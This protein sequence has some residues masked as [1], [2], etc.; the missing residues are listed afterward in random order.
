[1]VC[2]LI[3][4]ALQAFAVGK[5]TTDP[6][7]P[8]AAPSEEAV[9]GTDARLG[10]K[11]TISETK[12]PVWK[13]LDKLTKS[14]GVV[15]RAGVGSGDWQVR[16]RKMN[17]YAKDLPLVQIMNSISHVMKFKWERQGDPDR[18]DATSPHASVPGKWTYRL[19]MDRRTLLDAEAQRARAEEKEAAVQTKRRQNA[20]DSF[21]KLSTMTA[22]EKEKLKTDNP[23]LY[24]VSKTGWGDSLGAFLREVPAVSE[25]LAGGQKINIEG[26]SLTS[27][28][29]TGLINAM[30]AEIDMETRFGGGG[31]RRTYPDNFDPA[32][33]TIWV[34]DSLDRAPASVKGMFLGEMDFR[35]EGGSVNSPLINPDND[36]VKFMGKMLLE[37]EQENRP[38]GEVMREHESE[39]T[40][41][42]TR[43]VNSQAGGEPITEH[44][45]DPSLAAKV[46]LAPETHE[47]FNVEMDLAKASGLAVVSDYFPYREMSNMSKQDPP[48]GEM[49]VKTALEKI[50]DC[51]IY[52]WDKRDGAIELRDRNWFR[53]RALQI[54]DAWLDKW[55]DELSTTGTIDIDSL[56]QI[57]QLTQEQL[58]ANVYPDENLGQSNVVGVIASGREI[59]RFYAELAAD[60]RSG[61]SSGGLDVAALTP[62]QSDQF[63]KL[64]STRN[65]TGLTQGKRAVMTSERAQVEKVFLYTFT[66]RVDGKVME[67]WSLSTVQSTKPHVPVKKTPPTAKPAK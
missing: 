63:S 59:L 55:R 11:V 9:Q 12:T 10:Q 31:P 16:D 67:S 24:A 51:F 15:F 22:A 43:E 19:Y 32:K 4:C 53:K 50:G 42:M 34:N 66:L 60:Q 52:N 41:V 13:I 8:G 18:G 14:T 26:A 58:S 28:A 29:R 37:A 33:V 49:D 47:I 46:K 21:G 1:M 40:A 62:D 2:V 3:G 25:A 38:V 7:G 27:A 45:E 17:I 56:A 48:S 44:P 23:F 57:A 36:L 64:L 20:I 35:Y 65:M 30:K 54:P 61:L 39:G 6:N 5:V